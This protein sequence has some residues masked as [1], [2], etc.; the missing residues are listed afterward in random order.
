AVLIGR[1]YAYGLGAAGGRGVAR[2]IEILRSDVVRTLQLL[3]CHDVADLDATYVE[4][5]ETAP[6][7]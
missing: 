2:A 7:A 5:L 3:G 1:A 6:R 4:G